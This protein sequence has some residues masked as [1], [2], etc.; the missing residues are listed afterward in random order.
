MTESPTDRIRS[1]GSGS[2]LPGGPQQARPRDDGDDSPRGIDGGHDG[3][4]GGGAGPFASAPAYLV[5]LATQ[6]AVLQQLLNAVAADV[7]AIG[8]AL[9]RQ[10]VATP[11]PFRTPPARRPPAGGMRPRSLSVRRASYSAWAGNIV[12]RVAG[13]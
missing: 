12:K 11:S 8:A 4:R 10:G 7:E 5:A 1:A 2:N 9:N 6:N 13:W 3:R